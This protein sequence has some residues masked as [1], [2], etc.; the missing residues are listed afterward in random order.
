MVLNSIGFQVPIEDI[1]KVVPHNIQLTIISMNLTVEINEIIQ[2]FMHDPEKITI[3]DK[4]LSSILQ[5]DNEDILDNFTNLKISTIKNDVIIEP[6]L[7]KFIDRQIQFNIEEDNIIFTTKS[8]DTDTT[9][10]F[11]GGMESLMI[12]LA[13]KITF[14]K[15][16]KCPVS[17]FFIIDEN[18]SVM[19]EHRIQ[20]IDVVFQFLKQ[21][22][23]HI[24]IISHINS[25]KDLVD[26]QI[27]ITKENK[28]TA[29]ELLKKKAFFQEQNQLHQHQQQHQQ[30]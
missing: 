4:Q 5:D 10:N 20:N 28:N 27:I 30:H 13:L 3:N 16:C 21:H 25:I 11:Y 19:D 29:R 17:I 14:A 9:F 1:L 23:S 26:K 6:I 22:F 15:F 2:L 24:F 7:E 8:I 12:E 18:I